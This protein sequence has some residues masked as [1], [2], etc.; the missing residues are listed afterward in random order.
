MD[1]AAAEK[2]I[3]DSPLTFAIGDVHPLRHVHLPQE[4][5]D[6]LLKLAVGEKP[7]PH[8]GE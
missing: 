5:Q 6:A 8:L 7:K 4:A 2:S 1:A 3:M